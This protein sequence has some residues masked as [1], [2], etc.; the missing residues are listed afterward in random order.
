MNNL[1][2]VMYPLFTLMIVQLIQ[3]CGLLLGPSIVREGHI[4]YC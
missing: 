4:T 2:A 1:M 3:S